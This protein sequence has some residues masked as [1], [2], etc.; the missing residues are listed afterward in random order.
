V[1]WILVAAAFVN[2]VV[3]A[4]AIRTFFLRPAR[5]PRGMV[6]LSWAGTCAAVI[7]LATIARSQPSL[8]AGL[9]SL[10]AYLLSLGLFVWARHTVRSD[11]LPIAFSEPA[12]PP[13]AIVRTGPFA[14]IRHPFYSSYSLTWLA[15]CAASP[16]WPVL[17]VSVLML[18]T[19]WVMACREE[20]SLLTRDNTGI[21][22]AYLAATPRF[23]PRLVRSAWI[24]RGA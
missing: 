5:L 2:F 6:R 7:H 3:F 21:Y 18:G 23:I 1:P 17:A 12:A 4:R 19:Y 10:A 22:S 15:G 20:W 11:R 13:P 14:M 9:V 16:E 8:A 24:R